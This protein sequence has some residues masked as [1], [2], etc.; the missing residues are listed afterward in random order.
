MRSSASLLVLLLATSALAAENGVTFAGPGGSLYYEVLGGGHGTP[1][2]IANGGPGFGHDYLHVSDVWDR[3]ARSRPVVM[4]DQRGT[5]RSAPVKKDQS[6]TVADQVAD[7][8]ALRAHLGYEQFDLIGHSWG[9]LLAMAYAEAHPER[10]R[11]LVVVDSAA[12][13]LQDTKI[14]LT[15]FYP[16]GGTPE[17]LDNY[18]RMLFYSPEKRDEFLGHTGA[19]VF[20]R[21]VNE[22]ISSD[23]TKLDFGPGL[24]KLTMPALVMTGRYDVNVAP[25]TAWKIHQA[26]PGS[27][28]LAF[29]R[30]GHLPFF[31]QPREFLNALT[32]FLQ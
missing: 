9:G 19:M 6:C 4:Y 27:K 29:E 25:S 1:V 10:V 13:R 18:F 28:F 2:I 24:A 26:I 11:R 14:V 7:L 23:A 5:G 21:D 32:A 20:Q 30:S 22:K 16:D 17:K 3:L 15:D 31:E 12:P 8:D